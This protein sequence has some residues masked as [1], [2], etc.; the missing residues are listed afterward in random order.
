M[1]FWKKLILSG[2]G[3][4]I[5][6]ATVFAVPTIWGKPWFIEHFYGRV[7]LFYLFDHPQLLTGLRLLEPIGVSGHNQN[8]NDYSP[9]Q[10]RHFDVLFDDDTLAFVSVNFPDPWFKKR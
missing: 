7:F 1:K 5:V 2:L 9:A 8:L 3:L 4:F 6:A 10:T